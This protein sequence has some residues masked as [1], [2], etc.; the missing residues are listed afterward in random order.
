M[1]VT[2]IENYKLAMLQDFLCFLFKYVGLN[3]ELWVLICLP[4]MLWL[5]WGHVILSAGEYVMS[6]P[7]FQ[8]Q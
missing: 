4:E 1:I 3:L 6:W 5:T 8:L 2:F 7:N